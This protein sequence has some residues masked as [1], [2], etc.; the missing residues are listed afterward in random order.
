[1]STL[2]YIVLI[3]VVVVI[4]LAAIAPKSYHVHRS[5]TIQSPVN[6]VFEVIKSLKKHDSWSP[7][8]QKDPNMKK[9]F[10]GTDGEPGCIMSWEGNKDV[11]TGE[12]EI[13]R[14]VENELV[15]SE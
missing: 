15:D 14:I 2:L 9:S 7:W 6:Q 10:T 12:H 3:V 13:T 11:G 4:V 1:M 5:I 8:S